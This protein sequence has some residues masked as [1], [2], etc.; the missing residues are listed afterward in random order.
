MGAKF[1]E[2]DLFQLPVVGLEIALDQLRLF[3][4]QAAVQVHIFFYLVPFYGEAGAMGAEYGIGG[5]IQIAFRIV[6]DGGHHSIRIVAGTEA[7]HRQLQ[8]AAALGVGCHLGGIIA[9]LRCRQDALQ[10][11]Q[12]ATVL[13]RVKFAAHGADVGNGAAYRFRGQSQGEPIPG[14]QQHTFCLHQP[15]ADGPIGSLAEITALCVL[16]MGPA[17]GQGD[18]HIGDGR[19]GED[20]PVDFFGHM[21]QDQPLPVDIQR[22]GGTAGVK[23]QAGAGRQGGQQQMDLCIV[24]QGLKM[25]HAFCFGCDGLFVVDP[26]V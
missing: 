25:A 15:L 12:S 5:V 19:A 4:F 7:I 26:G 8:P 14:L 23:N 17:G 16:Q 20:A 9:Q 3:G 13:R 22:V 10:G 1:P 11:G 18:L 6:A 24:A 2:H 21:P